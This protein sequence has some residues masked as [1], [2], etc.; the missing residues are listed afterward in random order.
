MDEMIGRFPDAC[1]AGVEV[2]EIS[3]A[4]G[5][6]HAEAAAINAA[7]RDRLDVTTVW[8]TSAGLLP[9]GIHANAIGQ[10]RFVDSVVDAIVDCAT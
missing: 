5:Y 3:P 2:N 8:V 7:M 10:E 4:T 9:D 6:Q 1:L